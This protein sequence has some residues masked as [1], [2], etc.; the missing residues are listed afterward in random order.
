MDYLSE[1][2]QVF[3]EYST[4]H[5]FHVFHVTP[6]YIPCLDYLTE[7]L[8]VGRVGV[9]ASH[10]GADPRQIVDYSD[11]DLGMGTGAP[12]SDTMF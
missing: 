3:K 6:A 10:T 2:P 4:F 9:R 1:R 5:I 8:V 11:V 12:L 7:P